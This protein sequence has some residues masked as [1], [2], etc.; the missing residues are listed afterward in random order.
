MKNH[1]KSWNWDIFAGVTMM[2]AIGIL[3]N[4]TVTTLFE[5]LIFFAVVV[6]IALFLAWFTK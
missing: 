2:G 5:G 3:S 4:K 6:L 1:L